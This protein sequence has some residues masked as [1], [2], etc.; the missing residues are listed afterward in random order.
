MWSLPCLPMVPGFVSAARVVHPVPVE[1]LI[2]LGL[3]VTFGSRFRTG[4]GMIRRRKSIF[5]VSQDQCYV[6]FLVWL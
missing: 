4:E 3:A 1:A 2:F 5:P 6:A